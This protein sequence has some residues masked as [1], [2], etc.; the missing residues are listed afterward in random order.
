M[1]DVRFPI[2][3]TRPTEKG[4]ESFTA[5]NLQDLQKLM[6]LEIGVSR[7]YSSMCDASEIVNTMRRRGYSFKNVRV[8]TFNED[9]Y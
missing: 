1:G 9:E 2:M 6:S 5:Y 3:L 7:G 4:R 8:V